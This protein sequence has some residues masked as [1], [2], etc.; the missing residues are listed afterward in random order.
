MKKIT[1]FHPMN[2]HINSGSTEFRGENV[3]HSTLDDGALLIKN[4]QTTTERGHARFA[5]GQW[6]YVCESRPLSEKQP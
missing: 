6:A 3:E 4:W 2:S 1:V 5:P